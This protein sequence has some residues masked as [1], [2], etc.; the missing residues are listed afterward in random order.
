MEPE[1]KSILQ[2]IQSVGAEICGLGL[3]VAGA[4]GLAILFSG[5]F[6]LMLGVAA[7]YEVGDR[8]SAFRK[9]LHGGPPPPRH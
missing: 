8:N 1:R 4:V 7:V 6:L 9:W 2:S 3:I 5:W